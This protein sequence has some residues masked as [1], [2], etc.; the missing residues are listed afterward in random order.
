M[1]SFSVSLYFCWLLHQ[2]SPGDCW[3][4]C[5]SKCKKGN[6]QTPVHWRFHSMW[7]IIS[8]KTSISSPSCAEV[9]VN[10]SEC[11][12]RIWFLNSCSTNCIFLVQSVNL[13]DC[14][15]KCHCCHGIIMKYVRRLCFE[16]CAS[17]F[18]SHLK[19][20]RI[21]TKTGRSR[22]KQKVLPEE[23]RKF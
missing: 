16:S 12:K 10:E 7:Q 21:Q 17:V 3:C 13:Y 23:V 9:N 6:R 22:H 18:L 4:H 2:L 19:Q 5:I 14:L 11:K 15:H 1:Y 8:I 20:E